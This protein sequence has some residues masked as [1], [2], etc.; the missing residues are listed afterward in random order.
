M[1]SE[2][3]SPPRWEF[4]QLADVAE[5][6]SGSGFPLKFQGQTNGTF[7]FFK[8]G[9]M[10]RAGNETEMISFE[11]AISED[12]RQILRAKVFPAGTIVFPKIEAAIATNKKRIL[13][14]PSCVD[15]NVMGVSPSPSLESRFLF[16]LFSSKNLTEF[17]NDSNP[18]SIRKTAIENWR[19]PVPPPA[20]QRRLVAR[21]EAMTSRLEQ[22]RQVRLSALA[23]AETVI[24]S[25][26]Q[27][28]FAAAATVDW[29]ELPFLEATKRVQPRAGKLKTADYRERGALPIVDQGQDL[30]CGYTDDLTRKFQG[31]LPIVVFGDHTRNVKFVD[32]DFAV[33]ADGT[34]FL[35]PCDRI[36][37][38]FLYHWLR[39]VELHDLGY[40]RHFKLLAATTLRFP[41]DHGEQHRIVTRLDTL[42]AKQAKLLRLQT[43]TQTALAAFT[44][45]LLAKAFRG[46]L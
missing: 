6:D 13:T 14:R 7:P 44:P 39:A 21:I 1:S 37:H 28:A 30:I 31:P 19:I 26:T 17:A 33:G 3:C 36:E 34:V 4:R 35:Q 27:A 43:E 42:A 20:E 29:E 8:V 15:N 23:E 16:Y 12:V 45:A 11:H 18:P 32:F 41:S 38:R 46:E 9:D 40:S 10:T 24:L 2:S 25:V 22:A 5:V